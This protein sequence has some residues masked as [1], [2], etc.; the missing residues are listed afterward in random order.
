LG[1]L[2]NTMRD[3]PAGSVLNIGFA[4]RVVIEG[5]SYHHHK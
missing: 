2:E 3:R 1:N 5:G 4:S